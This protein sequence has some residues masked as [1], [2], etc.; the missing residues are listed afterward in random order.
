MLTYHIP[1]DLTRNMAH[2]NQTQYMNLPNTSHHYHSSPALDRLSP[3]SSPALNRHSPQNQGY[4]PSNHEY[5]SGD[6]FTYGEAHSQ[7][8]G[9]YS[10]REIRRG[11]QYYSQRPQEESSHDSQSSSR[12]FMQPSQGVTSPPYSHHPPHNPPHSHFQSELNTYSTDPNSGRS[13]FDP[14]HGHNYHESSA[15]SNLPENLPAPVYHPELSPPLSAHSRN[16]PSSSINSSHFS[17]ITSAPSSIDQ[18]ARIESY[19]SQSQ[20]SRSL[21]YQNIIID[22]ERQLGSGAYGAVYHAHCDQ[23]PCAA[24]VMHKALAAPGNIGFKTAVE[25]FKSEIELL[26]AIRHPNIVQY[27]T[28]TIEPSTG[29][30]VL[31]MEM[32]D[33]NLTSYLERSEP[34]YHEQLSI[35]IDIS[36][37]L[38][39]LH[40]NS[41]LHRDLTSNNILLSRGMAKITDFGMSKL[42]EFQ[43]TTL[44]PGN[45]VY[46]PPEAL[47]E[48]PSY[49]D[50]LDVFSF[51]VLMIQIM[52]RKF[53]DPLNRFRADPS[54]SSDRQVL[55][56][57]PEVERRKKHLDLIEMSHSLKPV[58]QNCLADKQE[59]RPSS[60]KLSE[61][62]NSMK[63]KPNYTQSLTLNRRAKTE[64]HVGQ[65]DH[66]RELE[67]HNQALHMKLEQASIQ[68]ENLQGT[69]DT[70][71]HTREQ[72]RQEKYKYEQKSKE[73]EKKHKECEKLKAA[74][75]D[76]EEL[77]AMFQKTNEEAE[78][79]KRHLHAKVRELEQKLK[80]AEFAVEE[81][82]RTIR[83]QEEQILT[84]KK[85][86]VAGWEVVRDPVP[87]F[88]IGRDLTT[89]HWELAERSPVELSAGSAV[90]IGND[91]YV[92]SDNSRTVYCYNSRGKWTALPECSCQFFSLAVVDG[93]LVTVGG[94]EGG[95][96]SKLYSY[97]PR[98]RTWSDKVF[99]P[100]PTARREPIT[101]TTPQYLIV[102]GGFNGVRSL[103]VV[104]IMTISD[105]KWTTCPSPLPHTVY[106]GTMALCDN[107]L[108]LAP[109]TAGSV[110]S[111]QM[112]LSCPLSDLNK[113]L[114]KKLLKGYAGHWQKLKDLPA[115]HG[116]IVALDGRILAVGGK[117]PQNAATQATKNVWEY[118]P[119]S[120]WR[121]VSQ[122]SAERWTPIV[123]TLPHDRLVV[124]GGQAKW[125]KINF[126]EVAH[127]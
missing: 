25:K 22:K 62:L 104:D 21:D 19:R 67:Q 61:Q 69:R 27:L 97:D 122:M 110:N 85:T 57:I 56:Q 1:P 118:M 15:D 42:A 49:T 105:R 80:Q 58:A 34:P 114:K 9:S 100:M 108:F 16:S 26:S 54:S 109:N 99:P 51:G 30:P 86:G 24:K 92:A 90:T 71:A 29:N 72:L 13:D 3:H 78:T 18:R 127:F 103:N 87:G 14:T 10:P 120:G 107:Q 39:H 117:S 111:Q 70:L 46:M 48:P 12:L 59:K 20:S 88:G 17:S 82:E 43:P 73:Y 98:S 63:T 91:V 115:P 106:G 77:L 33:E 41:L 94:L 84:L 31:L 7:Q 44:C 65:H 8:R 112:F 66:V 124:V 50:K 125:K 53:P 126:V 60:H 4:Y 76:Q 37:A 113:P 119:G 79:E 121:V 74:A 2:G 52:T 123:A 47:N 83:D 81:R 36:L 68:I 6:H 55:V 28:T 23:L 116:S 38:A 101:F 40:L 11:E 93:V 64:S 45:P 96:T 5:H 102:A 89:L 35:C 75:N 32:C 95:F